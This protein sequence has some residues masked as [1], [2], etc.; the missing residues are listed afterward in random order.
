MR[1]FLSIGGG[2]PLTGGKPMDCASDFN[3]L[4]Q[5]KYYITTPDAKSQ[6]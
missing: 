2:L 6:V 3:A 5:D 1:A 4:R